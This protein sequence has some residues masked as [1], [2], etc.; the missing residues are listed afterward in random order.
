MLLQKLLLFLEAYLPIKTVAGTLLLNSIDTYESYGG[1]VLI[2]FTPALD[3]FLLFKKVIGIQRLAGSKTLF[4]KLLINF[5]LKGAMV[6]HFMVIGTET[7]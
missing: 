1:F 7:H 6:R 2:E 5:L 3:L 4:C